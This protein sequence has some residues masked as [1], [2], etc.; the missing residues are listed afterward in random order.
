MPGEGFGVPGCEDSELVGVIAVFGPG[1][2][3]Q[4]GGPRR[5]LPEGFERYSRAERRPKRPVNRIT[6]PIRR[7]RTFP[8]FGSGGPSLPK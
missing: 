1:V 5:L 8:G 7:L 4:P 6:R 2:D 3:S